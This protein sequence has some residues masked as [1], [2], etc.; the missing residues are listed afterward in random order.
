LTDGSTILTEDW[1]YSR[2]ALL[3]FSSYYRQHSDEATQSA[4]L[5]DS[6]RVFIRHADQEAIGRKHFLMVN[7]NR[8]A[9]HPEDG[10][11][12]R[13]RGLLQITGFEKYSGFKNECGN[14]WLGTAPDSVE[15]PQCI[16]QFPY[17]V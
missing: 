3:S 15:N 5:K 12:F 8:K 2:A 16:V 14:Y 1:E 13:G 10:S 11:N 4:Y 6:H 17:S 7:G 9:T